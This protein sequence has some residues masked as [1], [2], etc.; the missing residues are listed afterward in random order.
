MLVGSDLKTLL[1][2][3]RGM[4]KNW[5]GLF[6]KTSSDGESG[7]RKDCVQSSATPLRRKSVRP[8]VTLI[9]Q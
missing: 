1:G 5:S 8:N 3:H 2:T 4:P 6:F 9:E 7:S